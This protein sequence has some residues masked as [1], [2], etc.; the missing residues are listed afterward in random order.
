LNKR[1]GGV[2][3][4]DDAAEGK[5]DS[6]SLFKRPFSA[7]TGG[8]DRSFVKFSVGD[9][10]VSVSSMF[11]PPGAKMPFEDSVVR[12][13]EFFALVAVRGGLLPGSYAGGLRPIEVRKDPRNLD[14]LE[15]RSVVYEGGA[16]D[17][18]EPSRV[19]SMIVV[20][21]GGKNEIR[22]TEVDHIRS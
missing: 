16:V 21:P 18:M 19:G 9:R 12:R 11:R 5:D 2:D 7:R 22:P 8:G 1:S 10:D 14:V 6:F 13:R 3:G 20:E 17:V 4:L 15:D